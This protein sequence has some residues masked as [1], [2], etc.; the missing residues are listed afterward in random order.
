MFWM[1]DSDPPKADEGAK[2]NHSSSSSNSNNNKSDDRYALAPAGSAATESALD[3][4]ASSA[5]SSYVSTGTS[6]ESDD[7]DA[8]DLDEFDEDDF[9]ELMSLETHG[10]MGGWV[11]SACGWL[12]KPM[13]L[14]PFAKQTSLLKESKGRTKSAL[15]KLRMN[16]TMS[17]VANMKLSAKERR[18]LRLYRKGLPALE[19]G[20]D[21]F[22]TYSSQYISTQRIQPRTVDGKEK[23]PKSKK[24]EQKSKDKKNDKAN[25]SKEGATSEDSTHESERHSKA[26]K[27][28]KKKR[29]QDDERSIKSKDPEGSHHS[30]LVSPE[31]ESHIDSAQSQGDGEMSKTLDKV[32]MDSPVQV[33]AVHK[34]VDETLSMPELELPES[35][36]IRSG[37]IK[38]EEDLNEGSENQE[39]G[40]NASSRSER[41]GVR[42]IRKNKIMEVVQSRS[43]SVPRAREIT[44]LTH[45]ETMPSTA[46][47]K[48]SKEGKPTPRPIEIIDVLS[49]DDQDSWTPALEPEPSDAKKQFEYHG[50]QDRKPKSRDPS[51]S[52]SRRSMS[53]QAR[54]PSPSRSKRSTMGSVVNVD[55]LWNEEEAKL[56]K[57]KT[58]KEK[59]KNW[60]R[61][62]TAAE[63]AE[64]VWYQ[65]EQ[66][67]QDTNTDSIFDDPKA[68]EAFLGHRRGRLQDTGLDDQHRSP[69]QSR[70]RLLVKALQGGDDGHEHEA[71]N[72]TR[73]T[74]SRSLGVRRA[75][76]PEITKA[77]SKSRERRF[78]TPTPAQQKDQIDDRMSSHSRVNKNKDL[79]TVRTIE[80]G[81]R[82][83]SGRNN[84]NNEPIDVHEYMERS[85]SKNPRSLSRGRNG[86]REMRRRRSKS[87]EIV[88]LAH[89]DDSESRRAVSRPRDARDDNESR[90]QSRSSRIV[91]KSG[92]SAGEW[93][94]YDT[95]VSATKELRKLEKKIEK[96]LRQVKRDSKSNEEL[97]AQTVSSKE[98]RKL[99]KQ[100]AQ[101]LK[102]DSE[103]RATKLKRIK[104]KVPK[105]PSQGQTTED[106]SRSHRSLSRS[107][108]PAGSPEADIDAGPTKSF[109]QKVDD[110]RERS[111]F[112]QLRSLRSSRSS[113]YLSSPSSRHGSRTIG[114]NLEER[115]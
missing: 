9:D 69:S 2:G 17:T 63:T 13:C 7:S 43:K 38:A 78:A 75:P 109:S 32:L 108:F 59:Q 11:D 40:K 113:R 1:K 50:M 89:L 97:D 12:D 10:I 100:L 18:N 115:D 101:K 55:E 45:I 37:S 16:D 31:E 35:E 83:R 15:Q 39:K 30:R 104:R 8:L 76:A 105:S 74:R 23:S 80:D 110:F 81:Q 6:F 47:R 111:K 27:E 84:D 98:I 44:D 96:Q 49:M 14:L 65:E 34:K 21:A 22:S 58:S 56:K 71:D 29:R 106:T 94:D 103:K 90:P 87:R 112:D 62:L 95:V 24:K 91:S 70:R 48:E 77:R 93:P 41:T 85:A 20:D 68:R 64:D 25:K 51:P 26:S 92:K 46:S 66:K 114:G 53:R 28:T 36:S 33:P 107:K 86:L 42:S 67:L 99:E 5:G 79:V 73:S 61:S 102:R 19:E 72:S 57:K 4:N 3:S 54:D 82:L 88:D 60:P 52:I